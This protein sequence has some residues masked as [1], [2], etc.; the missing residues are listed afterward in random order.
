M[1]LAL[2]LIK[3]HGLV[4]ITS[5][6]ISLTS[7]RYQFFLL[8]VE[9]VFQNNDSLDKHISCKNERYSR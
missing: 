4:V 9:H 3:H 6:K 5:I 8:L 1:K 7:A 2:L